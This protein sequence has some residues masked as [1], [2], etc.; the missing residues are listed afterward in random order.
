MIYSVSLV[1]LGTICIEVTIVG[2]LGS[3]MTS[4]ISEGNVGGSGLA[5]K[6]AYIVTS[7]PA[8]ITGGTE[9]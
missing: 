8:C 4:T 1:G 2:T 6:V 9:I 7:F 5:A 3:L